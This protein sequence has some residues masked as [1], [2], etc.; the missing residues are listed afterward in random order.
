MNAIKVLGALFLR[1]SGTNTS[2]GRKAT[3]AAMVYVTETTD[4]FYLSHQAINYL[5]YIN[6]NFPVIC[7]TAS[8]GIEAQPTS[9]LAFC[10]CSIHRHPHDRPGKLP[11]AP[12]T[13]II[14]NMKEWLLKT[15]A[16]SAFK[17]CPHQPL[18]LMSGDTIK[19]HLDP[20]ATP[21]TVYTAATVPV[22]WREQV[23]AQLD[24][25]EALGEI[26]KVPPGVPKNWQARL[27]VVPKG[28]GTPR[29]TVDMRPLNTH[30]VRETQQFV[31]PY[32]QARI[33]PAGTWR[34]VTD[35]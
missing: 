13:E 1:L 22:H 14:P 29:R 34:T 2:T 21:V 10:G 9:G 8:A 31:P 20:N 33:V 18:P 4:L 11:F 28:D 26:E 30:C 5:G 15:F 17:K 32:K 25:D 3:T 19:V 16:A 6:A 23:K 24:Q 35:A 7:S 27:H 12:V